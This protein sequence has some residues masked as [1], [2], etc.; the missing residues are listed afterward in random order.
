MNISKLLKKYNYTR[1]PYIFYDDGM[2]SMYFTV[3]E[4][5]QDQLYFTDNKGVQ[6]VDFLQEYSINQVACFKK[7]DLYCVSFCGGMGEINSLL[8]TETKNPA[9]F[10]V[11]TSIAHN[12]RTG[13]ITPNKIIVIGQ[14][15][16]I[17]IYQNRQDFSLDLETPTKELLFDFRDP[18]HLSFVNGDQDQLIIGYRDPDFADRHGS[19]YVNLNN[20]YQ[21]TQILTENSQPLYDVTIDPFTH[22]VLY[23][24]KIGLRKWQRKI[25]KTYVKN[26]ISKPVDIVKNDNIT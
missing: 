14:D 7:Q 12:I 21:Q 10:K 20:I 18:T 19:V 26:I 8:Y 15:N 25:A 2:P 11:V 24:K 1:S 6:K 13:A 4:N 22:Q 9:Q 5:G 3:R 23:S 16:I 17:K